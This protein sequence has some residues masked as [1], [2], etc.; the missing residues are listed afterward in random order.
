MRIAICDDKP[1]E[2]D[3]VSDL[4]NVYRQNFNVNLIYNT[5]SEGVS[6]IAD[7]GKECFDLL[8]L[9]ILMPLVNG[10][11]I[12]REVRQFDKDIKIVFLTVS[13]EFA[14]DSYSVNAYAYLLKP[15]TEDTLFPILDRLFLSAQNNEDSLA[16]K[17]QNGIVNILFSKLSYVEVT[18][19]KLH[20]HLSDRTVKSL[21]APLS[22]FEKTLLSR[23]EF[24]RVHRAF[25]VNMGHVQELHSSEIL[26]YLGE[27]VP[28]SRRL[29]SQARN[30]YLKFLML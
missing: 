4:L 10:M 17:L 3:C 16:L 2:L 22:D 14:L 8:L 28:V 6:L 9:D 27:K 18:N 20:F 13:P 7:L 26:T 29:Y 30:A 1:R 24:I 21:S 12:A 19:K 11:D 25:I 5:Y 15:V 23:P